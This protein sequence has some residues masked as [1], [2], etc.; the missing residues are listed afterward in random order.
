[1]NS[2]MFDTSSCFNHS[3][4]ETYVLKFPSDPLQDIYDNPKG[5]QSKIFLF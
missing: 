2:K 5:F 4:K 1:M 3:M